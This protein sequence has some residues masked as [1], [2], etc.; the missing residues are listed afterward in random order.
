MEQTTKLWAKSF[1]R[2]C[3]SASDDKGVTDMTVPPSMMM[4][5]LRSGSVIGASIESDS[6]HDD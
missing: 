5:K 1:S 3:C 2:F 6:Y 4:T